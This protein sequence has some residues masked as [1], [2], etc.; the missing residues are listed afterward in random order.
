MRDGQKTTFARELRKSESVA[1]RRLWA[2]LRNRGLGGFKFVRQA[3]V[4]PYIA[5]FLCREHNLIVEVDGA[6]HGL[7]TEIAYDESRTRHLND[8][9]FRV[10]RIHNVEILEAMDQVL[11]VISQ[12]LKQ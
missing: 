3:P 8:L 11:T 12:A 9:G 1:E 2:E 5:D 6:T 10:I 7:D 4:G